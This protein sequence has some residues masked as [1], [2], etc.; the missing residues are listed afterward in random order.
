MPLRPG[1]RKAFITL[2]RVACAGLLLYGA[3]SQ[4]VAEVKKLPGQEFRLHLPLLFAGA[5]WYAVAMAYFAAY[6][7]QVARSMG[8]SPGLLE[9]Q[10]AYFAS[11]LGKYIPGKAWVFLIRCALIDG[12]KTPVSVIV[13]STFY[14][15]LAMMAAGASLAFAV[16]LSVGSATPAMLLLSGGLAVGLVC[17]VWPP[18]FWRLA[19]WAARSFRKA[20]ATP[21]TPVTCRT[22][23]R[24]LRY[25]VPGWAAAGMSLLSVA[26]SLGVFAFGFRQFLLACGSM[27]LAIVG[28]FAV[29]IVPA[30]LGVREW[31]LMRTLGP[32]I[33]T[34]NAVLVAIL[35][36][37]THVSVELLVAGCLYL[38]RNRI[39]ENH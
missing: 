17:A 15:T 22:W 21:V 20:G 31:V 2:A 32:D 23:L 5:A 26:G 25:L 12:R 28:G 19:H 35:T 24:G 4:I 1:L 8:V 30:G 11:Q 37:I 33:G 7:C 9:T 16:L 29:L 6:W 3:G 18:L 13:A 38:F 27:A 14:E 39:N 34:G 36:R 10:G